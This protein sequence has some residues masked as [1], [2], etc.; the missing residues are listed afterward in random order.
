MAQRPPVKRV[1]LTVDE[2]TVVIGLL[3]ILR[4]EHPTDD[5]VVDLAGKTSAQLQAR[6][7]AAIDSS[8]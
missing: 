1:E 6:I 3:N 2:V 8:P 7:T 5:A 4:D